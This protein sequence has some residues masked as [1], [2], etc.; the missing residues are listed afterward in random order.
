MFGTYRTLLALMVVGYHLGGIPDIG[1][2]AVFG[3]YMLSGYLMT[4]I[5]QENYGYNTSGLTKYF[6]N[7]VLRIYPIYWLSIALAAVLIFYVG[8]NFSTAYHQALFF[9]QSLYDILRNI[10][11]FFPFTES[12]RLTPP[13]WALTVEIFFYIF[14]GLGI[15]KNKRI[16]FFWFGISVIYHIAVIILGGSWSD[17]YYS[18]AAASL[19]FSTGAL[20]YHFKNELPSYMKF[21]DRETQSYLPAVIFCGIIFNWICGYLTGLS[22][23]LFFYT[24]YFLCALMVLALVDRKSL[25]YISKKFDNFMGTLSYPMYLVHYQVGLFVI[26]ILG[27]MDLEIKRPDLLLMFASIPLIFIVSWV[28]AKAVE[29]PIEQLRTRVKKS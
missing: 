11:L 27:M 21:I 10:F 6:I 29:Q 23:S 13:A 12:P 22:T 8:E 9:P 20:I 19:P 28:F 5:M 24:N 26:V 15:S 14:I 17:R 2:Y 7:R 3:F 1:A 25:P 16:V 4:L 18:I